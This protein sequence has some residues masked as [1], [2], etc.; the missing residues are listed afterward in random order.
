VRRCRR[1]VAV[2]LA[3]SVCA[4]LPSTRSRAGAL[5]SLSPRLFQAHHIVI[6][7]F[8]PF[9][10]SFCLFAREDFCKGV[11]RAILS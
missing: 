8:C 9:I 6:R 1:L 4:P 7:G 5:L 11:R 2:R 10:R 3:V